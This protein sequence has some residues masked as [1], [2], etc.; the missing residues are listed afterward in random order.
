MT[1]D[2]LDITEQPLIDESIERYEWHEYEPRDKDLNK[3]GE[4]RIYIETQDLYTHPSESYLQIKG[5]LVKADGSA[6]ANAD[7]ITLTNNALMYCFSQI[8]YELGTQEIESIANPGPATTMLGLLKYPADFTSAQ[9]LN[10]CWVKDNG[11]TGVIA[12]N[13]GFARRQVYIIQKPTTKGSFSFCIPLKHIFGFCDE[14]HKIV[15]GLKH[16]LSLVRTSDDDAIFGA[17]AAGAAVNAVTAGAGKIIINK[18]AWRMPHVIPGLK[19]KNEFLKIVD[20]KASLPVAFKSRQSDSINVDQ[21]TN[22][23]WR[24]GFKTSPERPRY[25]IIG[26]QSGKSGDQTKNPAIFDH[27]KV[28]NAYLML[29][30]DRYP[31][32]DYEISFPNMDISSIYAAAATF[33]SQFYGMDQLITQSNITPIDFRD[34]FPLFVFDISKQND[35]LKTSVVDIVFRAFFEENVGANTQ[36]YALLISD[37]FMK[38]KA[39]GTKMIVETA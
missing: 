9:G 16:T 39:D 37:K 28:K 21:T 15:W 1:S 26:F 31:E 38:F 6:Y 27:I 8:K 34:L 23:T 7:S 33:S 4:I 2:I 18:I 35:R 20:S 12:E 22:F 32:V 24:L 11:T 29:N 5:Q 10:Q 17:S 19:E 3:Q 25:I 30:T 13:D 36:A 14:Y